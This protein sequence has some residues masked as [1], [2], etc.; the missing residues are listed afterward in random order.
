MVQK[1]HTVCQAQP[2]SSSNIPHA[3]LSHLR[4]RRQARGTRWSASHFEHFAHQN[5]LLYVIQCDT[6][7]SPYGIM[8]K[9]RDI[10][11]DGVSRRSLMRLVVRRSF[12]L[13]FMSDGPPTASITYDRKHSDKFA[14]SCRHRRN[15]SG[16]VVIR[17]KTVAKTCAKPKSDAG[18]GY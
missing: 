12:G 16:L 17:V 11:C 3:Y 18:T 14:P 1:H 13:R 4:Q 5:L 7:R 15:L 8:S 6:P 10:A 2:T 9:A